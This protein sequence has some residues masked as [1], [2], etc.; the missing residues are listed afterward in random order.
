MPGKRSPKKIAP[1]PAVPDTR[2]S[3]L[4]EL[5]SE[6][7]RSH[8]LDNERLARE[9]EELKSKLVREL[10]GESAQEIEMRKRLRRL[11]LQVSE[12]TQQLAEANHR[13]ASARRENHNLKTQTV[14]GL[15]T[16][17]ST[18]WIAGVGALAVVFAALL[19]L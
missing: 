3:E 7:K 17:P 4:N 12:L 10:E 15:T 9:I 13:V 14:K 8:A 1:A 5:L 11:E 16:L 18:W 6:E 19:W 2:V